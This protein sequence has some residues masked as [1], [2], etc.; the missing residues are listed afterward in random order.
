[1]LLDLLSSARE[2][3]EQSEPSVKAAAQLHIARVLTALDRAEAERVLESGITLVSELPEPDRSSISPS[4]VYL[5]AA[6]SPKRALHLASSIGE[7]GFMIATGLVITMVRHGFIEE[8]VSYLCEP[9]EGEVFPLDAAVNTLSLFP[10]EETR[11]KIL[12]AAIA[13]WLACSDS[14]YESPTV[15][16]H[17]LW[18]PHSLWLVSSRLG[19]LP[20]AEAREAL[21]A[22]VR[23]ILSRPDSPTNARIGNGL[24]AFEFLSMRSYLLFSIIGPLRGLDPQLAGSLLRDYPELAAATEKHPEGLRLSPKT[25]EPNHAKEPVRPEMPPHYI[26]SGGEGLISL[27][28]ELETD[29][30]RSFEVAHRLYGLDTAIDCPNEAPRECWPSTNEFRSLLYLAGQHD[31]LASARL[32]DRIQDRDLRLFAQIELAAAVA[33]LPLAVRSS[34]PPR[35]FK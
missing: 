20:E 8:A 31:G 13:G 33:G 29:F 27:P 12:R 16:W 28:E 22:I 26:S 25:S 1:M 24:E 23:Q 3:A 21:Q 30:R 35:R 4:M 11:R 19:I 10:G 5:A 32:L 18:H 34:N 17:L 7:P 15:A 9:V 14:K 2:Q 6:V